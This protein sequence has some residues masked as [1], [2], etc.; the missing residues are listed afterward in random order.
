MLMPE[1]SGQLFS[2]KPPSLASIDP[3][4]NVVENLASCG[5]NNKSALSAPEQET[6]TS[7]TRT[8]R[9][10]FDEGRR[11]D[12]CSGSLE[13]GR[14][15]RFHAPTSLQ[16]TLKD[17]LEEL[18]EYRWPY[19]GQLQGK[20]LAFED[21]DGRWTQIQGDTRPRS[22]VSSSFASPSHRRRYK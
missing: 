10:S 14:G 21:R 13:K 19:M 3:R 18:Q 20:T 6:V 1:V 9:S 4:R 11:K 17:L 22:T 12:T 2:T 16:N 15:F 7:G 5:S 8:G